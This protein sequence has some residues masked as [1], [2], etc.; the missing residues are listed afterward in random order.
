MPQGEQRA[1]FG[2]GGARRSCRCVGGW[3]GRGGG[4]CFTMLQLTQVTERERRGV[5]VKRRN[6]REGSE[7][8]VLHDN[9]DMIDF[10][11]VCVCV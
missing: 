1:G 10:G 9:V 7:R 11:S 3:S 6:E 5:S 8:G 2:G 4:P